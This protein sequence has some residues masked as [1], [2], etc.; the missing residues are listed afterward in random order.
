MSKS[1]DVAQYV[2]VSKAL[3]CYPNQGAQRL[4]FEQIPMDSRILPMLEE[5]H[6]GDEDYEGDGEDNR[7]DDF[8]E[9]GFDE[10]DIA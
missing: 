4:G 6:E 10:G 7:Y 3:M 9:G 5:V 1:E 2:K 8:E